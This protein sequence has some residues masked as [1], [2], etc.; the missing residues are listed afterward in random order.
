MSALGR[1]QDMF[2]DTAIQLQPVFA[3]WV[4]KTHFL[5]PQFTAP[6]ALAATSATWGGDVVAVGGKVAMMPIS[7]GTSDFLV[8]LVLGQVKLRYMLEPLV[9]V[10]F[11]NIFFCFYR[12]ILKNY[13]SKQFKSHSL[14]QFFKFL[15][16]C[17]V[18][19][20][21]NLFERVNQQ[22][23]FFPIHLFLTKKDVRRDPAWTK[24]SA[25]RCGSTLSSIRKAA[26]LRPGGVLRT[27]VRR[28]KSSATP[29]LCPPHRGAED[30][31]LAFD[32]VE[33]VWCPGNVLVDGE[34]RTSET[35]R[36]AI[37][38]FFLSHFFL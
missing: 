23:T 35:I 28:T 21:E 26:G 38:C 3:Q 8:W 7:L 33:A 19:K 13:F 25:T 17:N 30:K 31:V 10:Y 4:Q 14:K 18:R 1:P 24:S 22:V 27:A 20:N 34:K 32:D 2:S 6:N 36:E 15:E 11:F 29:G 37:S 9:F 16:K 5:A 12:Q